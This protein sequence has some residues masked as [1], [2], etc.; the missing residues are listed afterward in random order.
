MHSK[1]QFQLI[2]A[3]AAMLALAAC[4]KDEYAKGDT[5]AGARDSA[6]LATATDTTH[7]ADSAKNANNGWTDGNVLAYTSAANAGEIQEGELAAK[8]ATSPAVKAFARAMVAD[9][10]AMAAE[11]KT[12]AG[13]LNAVADTTFG[14][15]KS[16][17]DDSRNELKELTD[18]AAGADWDK[19]FLDKEIDGHKKVL[20]KIQDAAKSTTNADLKAALEKAAGKVQEHLTKAQDLREKMK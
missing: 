6:A 10:K 17:A 18:K 1:T 2:A 5:T 20:D 16:L 12:L 9:H 11:G 8:K 7:A 14:D 3:A 15:A 19:N 4:K 13:K